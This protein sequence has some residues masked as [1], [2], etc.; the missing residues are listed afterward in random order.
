MPPGVTTIAPSFKEYPTNWSWENWVGIHFIAAASKKA[1]SAD[2]KKIA[3]AMRGLKIDCPFGADGTVTMRA[4]DQTVIGYAI[5]WGTTIPGEPY[6][7]EVTGGDWETI[8]RARGRVE[9]AQQLHLIRARSELP[10]QGP[11]QPLWPCDRLGS[12]DHPR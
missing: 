8:L 6:V 11:G 4:D 9:E 1:N 7:P 10:S 3:E 5:G 2:G 12:D